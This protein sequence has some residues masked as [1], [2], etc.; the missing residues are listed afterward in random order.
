M[1]PL[2]PT[3]RLLFEWAKRAAISASRARLQLEDLLCGLLALEQDEE[4]DESAWLRTV[5]HFRGE[6][7]TWPNEVRELYVKAR[8]VSAEQAQSVRL[9]FD[10]QVTGIVN[11]AHTRDPLLPL[12]ELLSG[13]TAAPHALVT[14]WLS[15]NGASTVPGVPADFRVPL[16]GQE[17]LPD[18]EPDLDVSPADSMAP[19]SDTP[20][21]PVETPPPP[22][23]AAH[24]IHDVLQSAEALSDALNKIV[25]G[26][27]AAVRM[28][29][30]AYFHARLSAPTQGPRGILTFL[31]PPGVGKTLLAESFA[32]ELGNIDGTPRAFRRFDM[33][34]FAGHQNFEQLVGFEQAYKGTQKGTLTGFVADNPSAVV[35]F[36]E[37]EKAHDNTI[38]ALLPM[39]DNGK[40]VDRALGKP[41]S[42]SNVW[43]VFTTN[44]G[45]EFLDS[46]N[47][48]GILRSG[49]ALGAASAFELLAAARS[50][51]E[52]NDESAATA[53]SPE[54]VSR[55]AKGAAVV[56]GRLETHHL[57]ALIAREVQASAESVDGISISLTVLPKAQ[58][59][60]LLSLLPDCDARRAVAACRTWASGIVRRSFEALQDTLLAASPAT[61]TMRLD[62]TPECADWLG[63][64]MREGAPL[65]VLLIDDDDYLQAVL[66]GV[67][68]PVPIEIHRI[69][70][71]FDALRSILSISPD[72]VLLDLSIGV[73]G[74]SADVS[75]ALAALA[76]IRSA[77]PELPVYLFSQ[78]PEKRASFDMIVE[79]VLRAGGA[80]GFI[81]C[82]GVPGQPETFVAFSSGVEKILTD[83]SYDRL[84]NGRIRA[85][86]RV[87]FDL[88]FSWDDSAATVVGALGGQT[89]EIVES[90]SDG[91][92]DIRF[93]GIPSDRFADVAGLGRA[94][95][96]LAQVASWLSNPRKLSKLGVTPPRGFLLAGPPGT[97]KHCSPEPS[98]AKRGCLSWRYPPRS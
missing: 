29:S 20:T 34:S 98:L 3:T 57:M 87:T 95:R 25:L 92:A 21:A 89:D 1:Q 59:V 75:R 18:L 58:L 50:R 51:R 48:T 80:R 94:K 2:H 31:G 55:L 63:G 56:F 12:H 17:P 96:R 84:V 35:L 47:A 73:D 93:A 45:S 85:R 69:A 44:L 61:Y 46:R 65:R 91:R 6:A 49:G 62:V 76:S 60:F 81:P 11:A 16:P 9:T 41:I 26:Q 8:S 53:L 68:G 19:E 79:Q 88:G 13:I 10:D 4:R 30:D 7:L 72:L 52:V 23:S 54:F 42:F 71:T 5:L 36:D 78:S 38:Q 70:T 37:I 67:R 83:A 90:A 33:G 43:C 32:R 66:T 22:P 74:T 15:M 27:D 64:Q 40:V 39:L 77:M 97:G 14:E 82:D 28:L 24:Q 86:R